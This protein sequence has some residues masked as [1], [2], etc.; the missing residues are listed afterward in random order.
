MGRKKKKYGVRVDRIAIMLILFVG[1]ILAITMLFKS[2]SG[3]SSESPEKVVSTQD[4]K[5]SSLNSFESAIE[6]LGFEKHSY[7]VDDIH[8]G[9]LI[10]VNSDNE[11]IFNQDK[12]ADNVE[13]S[14]EKNEFYKLLSN[15]ITLNT[16][17]IDSLNSLMRDYYSQYSDGDIAVISGYRSKAEQELVYSQATDNGVLE[18]PAGFSDSHTGY[19]LDLAVLPTDTAMQNLSDYANASWLFENCAKYG[20][21]QRYPSDKSS[22]TGMDRP[23]TLRYVSLPHSMYMKENN[24]C[25]EEYI[26]LL[27]NYKFGEKALR[28]TYDDQE[29]MIYFCEVSSNADTVEVYVPKDKDYTICGNNVDG[30]IVTVKV[31]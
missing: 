5:V 4:K 15:T 22:I 21:I 28:Y 18:K 12:L 2:C 29:Y 27:R 26:S 17:T 20:F 30:F 9:E 10:L 16:P 3:S 23:S 24:L 13:V 11:Y 8:Y 14:S 25:L 1:I 31:N 19:S 6:R 7:S